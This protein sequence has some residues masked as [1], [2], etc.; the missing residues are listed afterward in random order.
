MM[1]MS[2]A[3]HNSVSSMAHV[4]ATP[5]AL[6]RYFRVNGLADFTFKEHL[7]EVLPAGCIERTRYANETQE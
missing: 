4:F 1:P 2:G 5:H 6:N 7:D 3:Q